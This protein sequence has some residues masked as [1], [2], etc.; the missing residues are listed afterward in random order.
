M[1]I[2]G[3]ASGTR[4]ICVIRGTRDSGAQSCGYPTSLR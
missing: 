1:S 2:D 4:S 3:I